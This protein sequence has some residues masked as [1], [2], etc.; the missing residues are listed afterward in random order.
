MTKKIISPSE[1]RGTITVPGSKSVMIRVVAAGLLASDP[2]EIHHPTFCDD[3]LAAMDVAGR[4]GAQIS[5]KADL[6]ALSGGLS[7]FNGTLRCGGSGLT[8][9]LFAAIA[10]LNRGLT[11]FT[12]DDSLRQRP[13]NDL[14]GALEPLGAQVTTMEGFLPL[15]VKGPIRG[16]KVTMDGS[17][18]SQYLTGLLMATPL[19]DQTSEILVQNLK[20]IPYIDLTLSVLSSFGIEV[21]HQDYKYFTI[22]G[23]QIY[24]GCEFSV[25]GDWS[26]A[27]FMLTA[28]ALCGEVT[29]SNLDIHSR[30][31]DI[32]ILDALQQ[33]GARISY[34]KG[35]VSV[36]KNELNAF[37]FDISDCPDLAPTLVSLAA[38]CKGVSKLFGA[39]RLKA[40][41]SDRGQVLKHEFHKLGV[42]IDLSG[43]FL[44]VEGHPVRG[45]TV[46]PH[47]DHRIAMAASVLALGARQPLEVLDP[48]C[49]NKSY[50]DFFRDLKKIGGQI[51][52]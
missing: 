44:S 4:L 2:T 6:V 19:L 23:G 36:E 35:R 50:P 9:R 11:R 34:P 48:E 1:I 21:Q 10:A 28:G 31:A 47:Q 29:I 46:F 52:E 5:R 45:G 13:M 33:A 42:P 27:A 20:S 18:S 32:R 25:E 8:L 14:A 40:K 12:G 16:G 49:V 43:D 39:D 30:Q 38:H 26:A 37:D 51:H 24:K 15:S 22:P 17:L 7:P 3:A 41:E